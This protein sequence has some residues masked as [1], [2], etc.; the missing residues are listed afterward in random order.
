MGFKC[1]LSKGIVLLLLPFTCK[2]LDMPHNMLGKV[3]LQCYDML[4][5]LYTNVRVHMFDTLF[6]CRS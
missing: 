1:L 3:G 4:K 5:S 2:C 6:L